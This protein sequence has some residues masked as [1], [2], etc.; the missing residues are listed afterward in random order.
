MMLPPGFKIQGSEGIVCKLKKAL[1]GLKQSPRVWFERFN[2]SLKGFGYRQSQANHTLF[3]K[4]TR[5]GT[6]VVIMYV[7]DMVITGDDLE[8]VRCLKSHI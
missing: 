5:K 1:Y 2:Y 7:D 3:I 4:H 8:E 6:T